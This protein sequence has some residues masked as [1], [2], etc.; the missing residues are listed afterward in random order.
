MKKT[1]KNYEN[2]LNEVLEPTSLIY[3][4]NK[5]R[6][7]YISLRYILCSKNLGRIL[8]YY[9]P[10]AFNVGYNEWVKQ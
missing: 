10:I 9:D 2:Y 8:R 6:G 5:S 4:S 3:L 1:K 7:K